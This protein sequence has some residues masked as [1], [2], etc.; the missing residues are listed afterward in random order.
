MF[1]GL[2]SL[3]PVSWSLLL[4]PKAE[5]DCNYVCKY[6]FMKTMDPYNYGP[7]A[8]PLALQRRRW[9]MWIREP[10]SPSP[11]ATRATHVGTG[12][13]QLDEEQTRTSASKIQDPKESTV[14]GLNMIKHNNC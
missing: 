11:M 2:C 3:Y 4:A 5:R 13:R 6:T 9:P 12:F 8:W 7:V 14:D 10:F 1:R